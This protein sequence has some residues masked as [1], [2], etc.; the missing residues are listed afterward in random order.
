LKPSRATRIQSHE[1][2]STSH[3]VRPGLR[4]R[5]ISKTLHG[6]K[7]YEK[8]ARVEDVLPGGYSLLRVENSSQSLIENVPQK[9]LETLVPSIGNRVMVVQESKLKNQGNVRTED[10]VGEV[11]VLIEKDRKRQQC[12]ISIHEEIYLL[13]FDDVCEI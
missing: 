9:Y 10:I 1:P 3:W 8:K 11:G 5:I 12:A 13:E 2:I 4:V 6:G 7:Y